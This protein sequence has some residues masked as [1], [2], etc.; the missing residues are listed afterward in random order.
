[1][2]PFETGHKI[3]QC[4]EGLFPV[5]GNSTVTGDWRMIYPSFRKK[6][7]KIIDPGFQIGFPAIIQ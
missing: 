3:T 2:L 7:K 4:V 5:Q 6:I 1:L